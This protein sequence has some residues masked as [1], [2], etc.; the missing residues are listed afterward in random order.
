[1]AFAVCNRAYSEITEIKQGGLAI[2]ISEV[3]SA[4]E[5]GVMVFHAPWDQDSISLVERL[6]EWA[7]SYPNLTIVLIDVVDARTQVYRQFS[8]KMLPSI[9]VMDRYHEQLG[10]TVFDV[11]DLEDLLRNH[12]II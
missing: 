5:P 12:R 9:I 10:E 6:T 2:N 8:L 11:D 3:L 4:D 7:K 1:M